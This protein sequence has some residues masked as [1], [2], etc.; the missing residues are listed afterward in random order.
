MSSAHYKLDNLIAILDF[1]GLQI[2][3]SNE[4]VMNINPIDEKFA[5]FGWHVIKIDGHDLEAIGKAVDE[6]KTI[7]KKPTI[8]IAKTVKGKGVSFMENNAGWHGTAP[9]ED[10]RKAAIEELERGE[11]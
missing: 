3:G 11:A 4:E 6:A 1:N 5:A 10:Q 2:D 9:N 7:K 8:I